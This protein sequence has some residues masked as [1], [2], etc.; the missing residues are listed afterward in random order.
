MT[1][2]RVSKGSKK[3]AISTV[4]YGI[5]GVVSAGTGAALVA[6]QNLPIFGTVLILAGISA[7]GWSCFA[8]DWFFKKN[9]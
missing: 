8:R 3:T 4:I 9:H 7:F 2:E 1:T 6:T 5:I